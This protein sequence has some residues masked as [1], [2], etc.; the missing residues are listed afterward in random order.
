MYRGWIGS[1]GMPHVAIYDDEPDAAAAD[2][3]DG[4]E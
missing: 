4:G 3:V 1:D 2:P